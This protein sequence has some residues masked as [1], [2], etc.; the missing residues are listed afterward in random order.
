MRF[1]LRWLFAFIAIAAI[2]LAALIHPTSLGAFIAANAA[3]VVVLAATV[4][5][6]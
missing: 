3:V 6:V 1:S 5:E 2:F 4:H